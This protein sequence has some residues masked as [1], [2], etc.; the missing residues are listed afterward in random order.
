MKSVMVLLMGLGTLGCCTA[1]YADEASEARMRDMMKQAVLQQR[2]A[3]DENTSLKIQLES[4][5]AQ[6][7]QQAA[8]P[9]AP[10]ADK[11]DD[12][13]KQK[14]A[15]QDQLIEQLNRQLA[16]AKQQSAASLKSSADQLGSAQQL[17]KQTQAEK[18]QLEAACRNQLAG[19]QE[20]T[21]QLETRVQAY[22]QQLAESEQKNQA[23]VSIS[24]ELLA[25][26]KQ[27]G[28]FS[29]LRDAEPLTGLSRVKLEALTQEYASKIRQQTQTTGRPLEAGNSAE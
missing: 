1:S 24:Q 13:L 15:Q 10:A 16:Q 22:D 25:R 4:L 2:A 6:L 17:L 11:A 19:Q 18:N 9:A 23:L 26:Y 29:A 27:K 3:Q 14:V 12:K 7:S 20:K 5:K 28:V 21:G 8:R